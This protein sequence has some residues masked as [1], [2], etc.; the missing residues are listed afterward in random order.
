M[1]RKQNVLESYRQ[2]AM[3][4]AFDWKNHNCVQFSSRVWKS[5]YNEDFY[6]PYRDRCSSMKDFLQILKEENNTLK[7]LI[8]EKYGEPQPPTAANVGDLVLVEDRGYENLGVCFAPGRA[9]FVSLEG[10]A[11]RRLAQC[12]CSWSA[13]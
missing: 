4:Q 1:D 13:E 7:G 10:L 11:E 5:L 12:K 2:Y 6:A 8:S 3:T 9:F